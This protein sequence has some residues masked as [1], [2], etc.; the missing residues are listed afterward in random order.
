LRHRAC[1]VGKE[2]LDGGKLSRRAGNRPE[3]A[4]KASDK[5]S[6]TFD[7]DASCCAF[8]TKKESHMHGVVLTFD[9]ADTITSRCKAVID[10]KDAPE[11]ASTFKRVKSETAAAK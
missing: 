8:D 4:L 1:R 2:S 10:G 3:M 7:L 5:K 9:D 11:H 6:I